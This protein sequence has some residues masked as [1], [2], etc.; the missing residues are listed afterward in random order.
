M[1]PVAQRESTRLRPSPA[2]SEKVG[3]E[4]TN[5]F[6]WGGRKESSE[7]DALRALFLRAK[8]WA[9]RANIFSTITL[10][11]IAIGGLVEMDRP[12]ADD[13]EDSIAF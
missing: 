2:R 9:Y 8:K 4:E 7:S 10:L 13:T 12:V 1:S 5:K 6:L 11:S 3:D